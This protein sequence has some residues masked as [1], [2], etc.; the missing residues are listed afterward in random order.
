MLFPLAVCGDINDKKTGAD[1]TVAGTES[2]SYGAADTTSFSDTHIAPTGEYQGREFRV[3][4]RTLVLG[5]NIYYEAFAE[6][7]TGDVINDAV[8]KRNG[9]STVSRSFPL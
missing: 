7:Q 2:N 8:Y 5:T 1:T 4:E 3:L 9:I 6:A